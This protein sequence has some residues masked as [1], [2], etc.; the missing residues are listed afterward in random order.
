MLSV[1]GRAG[2]RSGEA[3]GHELQVCYAKN[4]GGIEGWLENRCILAHDWRKVRQYINGQWI[5][6]I[7]A[8]I[9]VL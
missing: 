3:T 9:Q 2:G 1:S 6:G 8:V 7:V 5:D 4:V